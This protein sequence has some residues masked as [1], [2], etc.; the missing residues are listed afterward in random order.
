[1]CTVKEGENAFNK[2][3]LALDLAHNRNSSSGSSVLGVQGPPTPVH[4]NTANPDHTG[5][6]VDT[7]T[8]NALSPKLSNSSE[9]EVQ[10]PSELIS[11]CVSTLLM[12]QVLSWQ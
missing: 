8:A 10:L 3:G 9:A 4:S 7:T 11:S 12:I 5:S 6:T 2:I 1:M